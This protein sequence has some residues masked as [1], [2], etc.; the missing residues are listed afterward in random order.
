MIVSAQIVDVR[1]LVDPYQEDHASLIIRHHLRQVLEERILI[2]Q[3]RHGIDLREE[4]MIFHHTADEVG[5][6]VGVGDHHALHRAQRVSPVLRSHSIMNFVERQLAFEQ[7][8]DQV[9]ISVAILGVNELNPIKHMSIDVFARNVK[10]IKRRRRPTLDVELAIMNYDIISVGDDRE[11]FK[12][13][14]EHILAPALE[15]MIN[16][17]LFFRRALLLNERLGSLVDPLLLLDVD[18][19]NIKRIAVIDRRDQSSVVL[20]L[21]Y[22]APCGLGSKLHII[23]VI[24]QRQLIFDRLLQSVPILVDH[25]T[26]ERIARETPQLVERIALIE[27]HELIVGVEN[28]IRRL[29]PINQK[30]SGHAVGQLRKTESELS[31][32]VVLHVGLKPTEMRAPVHLH[33]IQRHVRILIQILILHAVI[34]INRIADRHRIGDLMAIVRQG[35]DRITELFENLIRLI[36]AH[37]FEH[38]QELIAAD[39]SNQPVRLKRR[40]HSR[41]RV[42]EYS[43]A[44]LMPEPIIDLLKIVEIEQD[45]RRP[46]PLG[47]RQV[48][49]DHHDRRPAIV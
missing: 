30:A 9:I 2:A 39:T 42:F 22:I 16:D 25:A 34:G 48:L 31:T 35:L 7:R 6:S 19:K 20:K 45:Q 46:P 11:A 5:A 36:G 18:H 12:Q 43:L 1:E 10:D 4:P 14:V 24:R 29:R 33:R 47:V 37:V 21:F 23:K 17:Q 8:I 41:R 38:R 3:S 44:A 40:L 28:F 15:Q 27:L 49:S 26:L 32:I 13:T